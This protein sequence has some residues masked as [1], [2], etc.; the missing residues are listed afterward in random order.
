MPGRWTLT[1]TASPVCSRARWVWPIDAAA[2]G[3]QSNSANSDSRSGAEL[4]LEHLGDA[5][6]WLGRHALLETGQLVAHVAGQEVDARRGDLAELDVDA[7]GLL[8]HAPQTHRLGVDRALGA[9]R[10][11]T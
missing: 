2:S 3:S 7:A 11:S 1:T 5:L 9:R 10:R 4:G 8:E 6:A